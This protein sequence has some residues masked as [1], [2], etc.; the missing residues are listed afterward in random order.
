MKK[1]LCILLSL[2]VFAGL[3]YPVTAIQSGAPI[4]ALTYTPVYGESADVEGI[5]Y[6]EDGGSLEPS[7]YR[8]ALYLQ[9]TASGTYWVKP[10]YATPYTPLGS[11]G[12]F[13]VNYVTGGV[14]NQAQVLHIML[15]PS[16]FTPNADYSRTRAAALDYIKVTRNPDGSLSVAPERQIPTG[17]QAGK[18]SG[19]TVSESHIALNIGFYTDGSSPG[20]TLDAALIRSQLNAIRPY[21]DTVRFFGSSGEMVQAYQIAHTLG[22]RVIGTAWLSGDA[23]ADRRELDALIEHC[24]NGLVSIAVVGSETLLR[25]NLTAREL[26]A[27]MEYVRTRLHDPSIPVTT[28][29]TADMLMSHIAVRN[30]C[31]VLFVN[32]YPYW[33]GV[34]AGKA[35]ERFITETEALKARY[36]DKELICSET[37]W[38]TQGGMVGKAAAGEREAAAYFNDVRAWSLRT[39][40]VVFYFDAADEPWKAAD[41]GTIGAHWGILDQHLTMKDAYAELPFFTGAAACASLS[42]FRKTDDIRTPFSDVSAGDWYYNNVNAVRAYGLMVGNSDTV[43]N[44]SGTLTL[45]EAVT[46]TCRLY[47]IYHGYSVEH[48]TSAQWYDGYTAYAAALGLMNGERLDDL[49][50]PAN[51]AEVARLLARAL[52]QSVYTAINNVADGAVPDVAATDGSAEAIYLLYRAGILSGSDAD[53]HFFPHRT[54]TRA[55]VAAMLTRITDPSLRIS[56]AARS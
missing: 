13:S 33:E 3:T 42:N 36:P 37:G 17:E 15:I 26:T 38:P 40:T 54:V 19:L 46:L 5:V 1:A 20:D 25:G 27:D 23:D 16:S 55:E 32:I 6:R 31:D 53:G 51:R 43:F 2:F 21:T 48:P 9:I 56:S 47:D 11:D 29:D 12:S 18:P 39:G 34:E 14:D 49:T 22:F 52:P 35:A 45:A 24:D 7:G 28:A 4:I 8:I 41:E 50:R 44:P 30:A 10:T